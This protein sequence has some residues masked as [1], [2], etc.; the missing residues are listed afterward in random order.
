ME[1]SYIFSKEN[2]FYISGNGNPE[3]LLVFQKKTVL[4]FQ[5]TETRKNSL[6]FRKRKFRIFQGTGILTKLLTFQEVTFRA[7]KKT[8]LKKFLIFREMEISS[9]RLKKLLTFQEVIWK[10][11]RSNKKNLLKLVSYDVFS[12]FTTVKHREIPCEANVI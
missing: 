12:V 11:W 5:E 10:A 7:G 2:F 9:H 3:F 8:T 6:Y 1:L 4:I